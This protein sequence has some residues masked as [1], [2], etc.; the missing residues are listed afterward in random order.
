MKIEKER[1]KKTLTNWRFWVILAPILLSLMVQV[2]FEVVSSIFKVIHEYAQ[3][4]AN[5][6]AYNKPARLMLDWAKRNQ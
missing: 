4:I 2:V 1:L 3:Y 5:T 6:V